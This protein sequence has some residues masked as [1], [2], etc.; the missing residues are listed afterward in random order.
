MNKT[1]IFVMWL[2]GFLDASGPSLNESQTQR[3][4]DKLNNIF[5]HEADTVSD[6]V[7]SKTFSEALLSATKNLEGKTLEQLGEEH[8]FDVHEGFPPKKTLFG[9]GPDGEVYRC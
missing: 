2:D 8:G 6:V 9:E 7:E 4:K 5:V 1:Q 3:I